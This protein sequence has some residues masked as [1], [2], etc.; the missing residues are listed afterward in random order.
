MV[1]KIEKGWK[2]DSF[3]HK[4]K[5]FQQSAYRH[6][7]AGLWSLWHATANHFIPVRRPLENGCGH[8]SVRYCVYVVH[9]N[10][11]LQ[12][13]CKGCNNRHAFSVNVRYTNTASNAE[14]QRSFERKL[15]H[16]LCWWKLGH[17]L[18]HCTIGYFDHASFLGTKA[19]ETTM[20]ANS[21]GSN[22]ETGSRKGINLGRKLAVTNHQ[23][24]PRDVCCNT[25]SSNSCKQQY[26]C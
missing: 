23:W 2:V 7:F 1:S 15:L 8:L 3:G 20:L 11:R 19:Q 22:E 26:N 10:H 24:S 9:V 14:S 5:R 18:E 17:V 6:P 16:G 13:L 4:N 12:T 21:Y 25:M